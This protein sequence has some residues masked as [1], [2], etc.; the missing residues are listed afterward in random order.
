MCSS[1]YDLVCEECRKKFDRIFS[2]RIESAEQER[3]L[4][5]KWLKLLCEDCKRLLKDEG[6]IVEEFKTLLNAAAIEQLSE[7]DFRRIIA[8]L[9]AYVGWT[10]KDYVADRILKSTDFN[11]LRS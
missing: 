7:P 5:A 6:F 10:N 11:T 2:V 1:A 9:W 4:L 8:S 3:V